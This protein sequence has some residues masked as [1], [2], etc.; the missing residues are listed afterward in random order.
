MVDGDDDA[1]P[2]SKPED[3]EVPFFQ[4]KGDSQPSNSRNIN[5]VSSQMICI[6]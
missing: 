5:S 6:R 4:V 1:F 3:Q 2:E